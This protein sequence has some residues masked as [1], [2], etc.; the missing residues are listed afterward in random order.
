MEVK[1]DDLLKFI[2]TLPDPNTYPYLECKVII[3]ECI[4][5]RVLA[6]FKPNPLPPITGKV[7]ELMFKKRRGRFEYY[8][9]LDC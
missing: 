3:H 6:N 7:K 4:E 1:T 5:L 9:Y 2:Q 8:W